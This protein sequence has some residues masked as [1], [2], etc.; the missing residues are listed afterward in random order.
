M[1]WGFFFRIEGSFAAI[2]ATWAINFASH[3]VLLAKEQLDG[4][5]RRRT[6]LYV[7]EPIL[8]PNWWEEFCVRGGAQKFAYV[9]TQCVRSTHNEWMSLSLSF[10]AGEWGG[11]GAWITLPPPPPPPPSPPPPPPLPPPSPP[12]PPPPSL[13][14][15]LLQNEEQEGTLYFT[16]L[17]LPHCCCCGYF[18]AGKNE[19]AAHNG[20]FFWGKHFFF[21]VRWRDMINQK[22]TRHVEVWCEEKED[23]KV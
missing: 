17:L 22:L 15:S 4:G 3:S 12:P 16:V 9:C 14:G 5:D 21:Y 7:V 8:H 1:F 13:L 10:L 2:G 11:G 18:G 19:R 20:F 23:K 6:F